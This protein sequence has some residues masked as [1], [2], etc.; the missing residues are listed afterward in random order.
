MDPPGV[1]LFCSYHLDNGGLWRLRGR[2]THQPSNAHHH[3]APNQGHGEVK[4][5][6]SPSHTLRAKVLELGHLKKA[7]EI[8]GEGQGSG[9]GRR[10]E[11]IKTLSH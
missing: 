3:Y 8:L 1:C 11:S 7:M 2:Y 5:Q 4:P 10:V 6:S 9:S